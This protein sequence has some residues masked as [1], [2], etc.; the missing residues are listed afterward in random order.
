MGF[1]LV[2]G[3]PERR[4][5]A[6][7]PVSRR[8]GG[9]PGF[10]QNGPMTLTGSDTMDDLTL[11][12]EFPQATAEQWRKL[13]EGVLKGADFEKRLVSRTYEGLR[14][15]PLYGKAAGAPLVARAE[16]GRW[17]ICQRMDH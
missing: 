15:E 5:R 1:G 14:I 10:V 3:A 8:G 12:A 16:P 7:P 2:C 17:R 4:L 11:A 13:V 9:A 6:N